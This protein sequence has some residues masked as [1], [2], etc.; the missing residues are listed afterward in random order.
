MAV[1]V[2]ISEDKIQKRIVELADQ[3]NRDYAGKE[4]MIVGILNGAFMFCADLIRH[5]KVPVQL[6]FMSASSYGDG[7][8]SSGN[9]KINMDVKK[10]MTGKH[11][12]LIEDIVDT[13]LTLSSLMH[14]L[15]KRKPAS[16]KLCSLLYKPARIKHQVKI[17]YLAFEIEDHFVIGYGL[18]YAGAYRELPYIGIY[19]HD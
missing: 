3:I 1:D 14:L 6:E 17:D 12:L 15:E 16:L 11:V 19:Q 8:E 10:E 7:T 9:V 4:I 5:I 2:F 18:D 13:G